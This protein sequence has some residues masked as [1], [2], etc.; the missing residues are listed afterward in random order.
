[1]ANTAHTAGL[2]SG[3]LFALILSRFQLKNP[4]PDKDI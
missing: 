2:I 1:M 3:C 4:S